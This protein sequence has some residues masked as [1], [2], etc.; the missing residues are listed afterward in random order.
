MIQT[1]T[2]LTKPWT[3]LL[4]AKHLGEMEFL[5]YSQ[6]GKRPSLLKCTNSSA[7]TGKNEMRNANIVTLYKNQGDKSDCNN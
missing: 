3:P 5:K 6:D 2:N 1:S 4:P 7:S